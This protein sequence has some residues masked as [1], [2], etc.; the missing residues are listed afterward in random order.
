MTCCRPIVW[1]RFSTGNRA[2][3]PQHLSLGGMGVDADSFRRAAADYGISTLLVSDGDRLPA[4]IDRRAR[5]AVRLANRI[6]PQANATFRRSA[7]RCAAR[8][9]STASP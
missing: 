9:S 8:R 1:V 6:P 3:A 4:A 2:P 7:E 5:R